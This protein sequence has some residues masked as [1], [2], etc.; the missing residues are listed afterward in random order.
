MSGQTDTHVVVFSSSTKLANTI[1]SLLDATPLLDDT[2]GHERWVVEAS[3]FGNF[4][5]LCFFF[6]LSEIPS[7]CLGGILHERRK[8]IGK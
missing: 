7:R 8:T 3:K 2:H 5:V 6:A 1:V 4:S